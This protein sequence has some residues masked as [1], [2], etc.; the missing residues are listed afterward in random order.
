M[1]NNYGD[2]ALNLKPDWVRGAQSDQN[3]ALM[4]VGHSNGV[5]DAYLT[6]EP[7]ARH[8]FA[9][10]D[11]RYRDDDAINKTKGYHYVKNTTWTKTDDLWEWDAEG[12]CVF[13]TYK[14][15][16]RSEDRFLADMSER[17]A[18]RDRVMGSNREEDDAARIAERAGIE[19]TDE[20]GR[21]LKRVR[22]Q[23]GMRN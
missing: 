9:W 4:M 5:A 15:M 13:K 2:L 14:L 3:Y 20:G 7:D 8:Q 17:R 16:A 12:F 19:V 22:R 11:Q 21:P 10:V 23:Q 18:Q 6:K 1:P